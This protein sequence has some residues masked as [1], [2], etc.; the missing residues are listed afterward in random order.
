M[1]EYNYKPNSNR[2]REEQKEEKKVEKVVVGTAKTK[3]KSG[4][5]KLT[6]IFVSED[7]HNVK[8]YIFMDVLVPAVKDAVSSVVKNGIDMLVYG[9]PGGMK[10]RVGASKVSYRD[11]Y[12]RG[13]SERPSRIDH[14]NGFDYD[15]I[16]FDNRGDAEAVLSA[17]EDIIEQYT[18][19][20]V[21][22]FYELANVTT[23]NYMTHKYGW[24]N[25]HSAE[26][27]RVRSGWM[28]K[29]PRPLPID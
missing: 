13:R 25:I 3:K 6:D 16:E 19:V 7:I 14:T 28:I 9:E 20:S 15:D 10:K 26:V 22:D 2:S 12:D 18:F 11:Y 21:H 8:N 29:L 4:I 24:T 1:P 23:N 5:H 27:R 17:M